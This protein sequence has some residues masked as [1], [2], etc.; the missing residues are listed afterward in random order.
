MLQTCGCINGFLL[1]IRLLSGFTEDGIT[2]MAMALRHDIVQACKELGG[3]RPVDLVYLSAQTMGDAKL[4]SE[5]LRMF[6]RQLP[7]YVELLC[8][9]VD[10]EEIR[11][12]A[13]TM[14]GAARS[15]GA[16]QL[17]EIASIAEETC[18]LDAEAIRSEASEVLDFIKAL[19]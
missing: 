5:I 7:G 15:I 12:C 18:D 13:H 19:G 10:A 1:K 8:T 17:A 3:N 6:A 2:L 9:A 4:E 16:F 14:K 11:K